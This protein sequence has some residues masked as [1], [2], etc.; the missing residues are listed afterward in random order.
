MSQCN[1]QLFSVR[2][3]F[4]FVPWLLGEYSGT[5]C[6]LD[7]ACALHSACFLHLECENDPGKHLRY[8]VCCDWGKEVDLNHGKCFP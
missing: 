6:G 2:E 3:C 7:E 5:L 4:E 1:R 8:L